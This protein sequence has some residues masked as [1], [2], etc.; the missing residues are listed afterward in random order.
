MHEILTSRTLLQFPFSPH[1]SL[2]KACLESC[3]LAK[4]PEACCLRVSRC[5]GKNGR[6]GKLRQDRLEVS[7]EAVMFLFNVVNLNV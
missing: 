3:S 5:G 4:K 7:W 1:G 2:G 6:R